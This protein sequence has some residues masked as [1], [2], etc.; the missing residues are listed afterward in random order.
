MK[1]AE[2][3]TTEVTSRAIGFDKKT[4]IPY[5]SSMVDLPYQNKAIGLK[6]SFKLRQF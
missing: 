5:R 4:F 3:A 1:N 6:T 2:Q